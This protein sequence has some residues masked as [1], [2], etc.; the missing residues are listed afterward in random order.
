MS[1]LRTNPAT[2]LHQQ[3]GAADWRAPWGERRARVTTGMVVPRWTAVTPQCPIFDAA[4]RAIAVP[5]GSEQSFSDRTIVEIQ[6]S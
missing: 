6:E 3:D 5:S 4:P 1:E 2:M